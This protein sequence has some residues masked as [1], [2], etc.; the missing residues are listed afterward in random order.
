MRNHIDKLASLAK[1]NCSGNVM[2]KILPWFVILTI[3]LTG[4]KSK[5][6]DLVRFTVIN[7]S[8][9]PLG[10]SLTGLFTES[11][12]YLHLPEGDPEFPVERTFTIAR[13]EYQMQVYYID[14]W[15]PVYG[16]T[17]TTGQGGTLN[18]KSNSTITVKHC[19]AAQSGGRRS[20]GE[21]LTSITPRGKVEVPVSIYL[22]RFYTLY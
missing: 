22:N 14:L 15:D 10:I 11:I 9:F 12:Y 1:N 8:P 17:C 4:A 2:K 6:F 16:Y 5:N 13:D 18:A 19:N 21:T 7:E 3:L 20:Q